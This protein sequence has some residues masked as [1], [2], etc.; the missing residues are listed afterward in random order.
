MKPLIRLI[1]LKTFFLVAFSLLIICCESCKKKEV[2]A[3]TTS[4]ITSIT[5][6]SAIGGGKV[7]SDGSNVIITQGSCWNNTGSPTINDTK[8]SDGGTSNDFISNLSGLT[9]NTTYYVRAYATNEIGTGY[10]SIVM[11]KT[12]PIISAAITST[13]ISSIEQSSAISGGIIT[14][15]GEG[16]ISARGICWGIVSNPT[17]SNSKT[18]DGS[19]LGSFVSYLTNLQAGT[20]YYVRAY[21]SNEAGT[22]YGNEL[23]FKTSLAVP[24]LATT[25]ISLINAFSANS[26]GNISM[27]GGSDI[28]A[29]GVCWSTS[30]NPTIQDQKT[31]NGTGIGIFSSTLT[32]LEKYTKYYIRAYA[33]NS[34]GTGYG[35]EQ[36]ILTLQNDQ[37]ADIDGNIYNTISIGSQ[38]WMK[39]NLKTTRYSNG[40]TISFVSSNSNWEALTVND[41]A[42][43]FYNDD[44]PNGLIWGALYTWSAAVN[45]FTGSALNPSNIQGVCPTGWHL[46]SDA[47]W[48]QLRDYLGGT[49]IAGGKLKETGFTH[50]TYPNEGATNVSG[51]TALASGIRE[52]NN[53]D[54]PGRSYGMYVVGI[55]WSATEYSITEAN[56]WILSNSYAGL[57][58]SWY[59][60]AFGISVRCVKN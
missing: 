3:L 32:N 46:P 29:R 44:A 11:F 30:A 39:E 7:L 9:S 21:A 41:K 58:K 20:I 24:K 12:N 18:S 26:G 42:Y 13:N 53:I 45:G 15:D 16:T 34:I 40:T 8:T 57:T 31:N 4:A 47:E 43:C 28:T 50:W 2:P 36:T 49:E 52:Q 33:T 54:F 22:I 60:R 55:W 19:G 1:Q 23:S 27:D 14:S 51:F 48:T 59:D 6:S 38:V 25:T 37:I 5:T 35:N 10:G 17:I 56:R